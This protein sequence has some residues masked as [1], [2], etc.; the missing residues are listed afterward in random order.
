MTFQPCFQPFSNLLN[1]VGKLKHLISGDKL[2]TFQ[3]F[4]GF[5]CPNTRTRARL[6]IMF[7]LE[8]LESIEIMA[9]FCG[10]FFP[11][12]IEKLGKSVGKVGKGDFYG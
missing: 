6:S 7:F 3:P 9:V 10:F 2:P 1:A 12:P 4:Q 8:R 11:T 5:C